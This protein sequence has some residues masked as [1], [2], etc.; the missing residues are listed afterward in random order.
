[1]SER[2]LEIEEKQQRQEQLLESIWRRRFTPPADAQDSVE[3][4]RE[5]RGRNLPMSPTLAT[6]DSLR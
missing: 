2:A 6:A 5:D 3:L 4:L 1:M